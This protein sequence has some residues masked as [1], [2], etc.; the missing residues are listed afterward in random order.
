MIR[1]MISGAD[2]LL[3]P[4]GATQRF[5]CHI[6]TAIR[7]IYCHDPGLKPSLQHHQ[8]AV[9]KHGLLFLSSQFEFLRIWYILTPAKQ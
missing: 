7:G 9:L 5:L 6:L 4:L 1:S 3:V 8:E 2:Q